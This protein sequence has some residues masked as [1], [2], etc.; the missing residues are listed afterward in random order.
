MDPT[1]K[2]ILLS[3]TGILFAAVIGAFIAGYK[4]LYGRIRELETNQARIETQ[5]QPLWAVVQQKMVKDLTHPSAEFHEADELLAKLQ[6]GE[7]DDDERVLLL[8]LMEN[9]VVDPNPKVGLLERETAG[10]MAFVMR[11]VQ[12]EAASSAP[13]EIQVVAVKKV[14]EEKAT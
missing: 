12:E 11:K 4:T 8:K 1:V 14:K 2:T 10:G 5:V 6:S 13:N 7:I 3:F 9:R